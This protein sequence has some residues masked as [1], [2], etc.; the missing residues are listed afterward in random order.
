[1][2]SEIEVQLKILLYFC[3][4]RFQFGRGATE[5]HGQM[6]VNSSNQWW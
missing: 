1:M 6:E 5:M 3:I 4:F 2:D